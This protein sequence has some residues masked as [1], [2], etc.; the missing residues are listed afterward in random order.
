MRW[1]DGRRS[2]NVEDV[3][4]RGGAG[5]G[6][7]AKLGAGTLIAVVAAYFLGVDPQLVMG[8][9]DTGD[10]GG[11]T[12]AGPEQTAP[13]E[14]EAGQ[15]AATVLGFTEVVWT[16]LF[17]SS[18]E[19]YTPP[20]LRLFSGQDVS[21]C[22]TADAAA[23]PFY[24]PADQKVYVDLD[25]FRELVQRFGGPGDAT[26]VGSFAQAY[27]IAHEVGHHVQTLTGISDQ[28]R[29][30]QARATGQ[31]GNALQVR[32]ELQADCYAGVWAHYEQDRLDTRDID[33]A[34]AAAAA[35]GDDMIQKKMQGYVVP[36][37]F[38]HGSAAQRQRWFRAGFAGGKP[39]DCDTFSA[40]S[41]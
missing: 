32:M 3:R 22:G 29:R 30:S 17:A 7:G 2:E 40:R 20:R 1:R 10:L 39:D 15:Y 21:G 16:Q 14:D 33:S 24:C 36:E 25:F 23:G 11:T 26:E 9:L 38:T 28:V 13:P 18:G 6:R 12:Q 31:D 37:S 19:R 5:F 4:G 41:L 34:L 35:V 27:V 8:L